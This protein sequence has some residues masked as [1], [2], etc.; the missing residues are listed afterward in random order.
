MMLVGAGGTLLIIHLAD[1][2][3]SE[4][5]EGINLIM[6]AMLTVD[7]FYWRHN[8][9]MGLIVMVLYFVA[10]STGHDLH[11]QWHRVIAANFF[12]GITLIFVGLLTKL[13]QMQHYKQY[14]MT[15]EARQ[16]AQELDEANHKLRESERLKDEFLPMFPTSCAPL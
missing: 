11:G 6:L 12:M 2:P 9:A 1:G 8:V 14:L 10:V 5:Y 15:E 16:K 4:Y 3:R 7:S 13:Y